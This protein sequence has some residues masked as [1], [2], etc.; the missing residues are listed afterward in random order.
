MESR[1]ADRAAEAHGAFSTSGIL[2]IIGGAGFIA[3]LIIGGGAGTAIAIAGA[4]M[5]L[6]GLYLYLR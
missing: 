2:M 6:Y 1:I 3:G 5:A 4:V